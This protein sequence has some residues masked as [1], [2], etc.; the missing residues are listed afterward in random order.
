MRVKISYQTLL[1]PPPFAFGYTLDLNINDDETEIEFEME[2]LNRDT[3]TEDEITNEGFTTDDDFKWTGKL[4]KV[5]SERLA[6]IEHVELERNSNNEEIWMHLQV[7]SQETNRSGHVLN[8]DEWDFKIQ[9]LIQ[10]IYEKSKRELPLSV[11][12][13]IVKD[14]NLKEVK[15]LGY[16]ETLTSEV[17]GKPLSWKKM[18][19]AMA[20]VFSAEIE[21][22]GTKKPTTPGI[23]IDLEGD[24]LY[25]HLK[26]NS[27]SI[28]LI[29]DILLTA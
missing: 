16:F 25:Y 28:N 13:A 15:V 7:E 29:S 17:N 26:L 1:I 11:N 21:E 9:E 5:W 18:Q 8:V 20:P 12:L 2:Y 24:G 4:D 10:A 27:K 14:S 23:W 3:I 19:E 22:E 6:E